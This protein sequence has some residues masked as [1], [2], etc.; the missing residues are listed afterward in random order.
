MNKKII[1][2]YAFA[3]VA[4]VMGFFLRIAITHFT[5]PGLATYITF[6]PFIMFAAI[7]GGLGPGLLTTV[8]SALIVDY[9]FLSPQVLLVPNNLADIVGLALFIIMGVLISAV[10]EYYQRNQQ[11]FYSVLEKKLKSKPQNLKTR[12][13]FWQMQ[14]KQ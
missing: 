12:T 8:T 3:L 13:Y 7:L 11:K 6:Y 14:I 5:G 2:S 10:A 9:W 4:T 1:I